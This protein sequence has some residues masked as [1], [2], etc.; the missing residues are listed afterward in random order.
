[1]DASQTSRRSGQHSEQIDSEA[2]SEGDRSE[3]GAG[4]FAAATGRDLEQRDDQRNYRRYQYDLIAP[5]CGP[6]LLEV[7]AGLGDFSSQFTDR[8]RLIV[9]DVDPEAVDSMARRFA[10][11]PTVDARR[12]DVSTF[13][14]DRARQLAEQQGQV[15]SV[16]A[17]NVLEHIEDDVD[18]LHALSRLV[19][20]G[21][22]VVQWV[23]GYMK[24]YGE[25]DRSVGHVRRYTPESL[26]QTGRDAGLKVRTCR[27]V[28]LLGGIAWWA[29]V[30]KGGTDTPKPG[31]VKIYDSMVIPVS[32][33]L[34]RFPIPFGQTVLGVFS[35]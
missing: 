14:P 27:P 3:L 22:T 7:G 29:A 11:R 17:I 6:E 26:A 32:R 25:F 8:E 16:L 33:A 4:A 31:L 35:V 12:L 2:P 19:R 10:D 21:G 30:R 1:M 28:N 20:P 9:T 23:P 24:L 13:T 15:D 34:D 5:H 18:T